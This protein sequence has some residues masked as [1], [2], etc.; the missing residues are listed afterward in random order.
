MNPDRPLRTLIDMN[1][2]HANIIEITEQNFRDVAIDGTEPVLIDFWAP[3]CG[4]CR[5]MTPILEEA[6][7]L[8]SGVSQVGKVNVDEQPRLADAFGV[9]GIPTLVLMREGRVLD[10]V[11]GVLPA[12]ALAARVKAKL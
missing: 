10:A 2:A 8:L 5:M 7:Q 6:A 12:A 4:P 11:S 3:W 9:R 1:R